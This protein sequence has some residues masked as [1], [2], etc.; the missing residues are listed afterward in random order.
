MKKLSCSPKKDHATPTPPQ[1]SQDLDSINVN[2]TQKV[3][4]PAPAEVNVS[5]EVQIFTERDNEVI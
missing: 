4:A 1:S 5:D 2:K 3:D